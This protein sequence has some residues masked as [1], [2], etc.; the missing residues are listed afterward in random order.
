MR[1]AAHGR[2]VTVPELPEVETLRQDLNREVVGRKVKAVAVGNG[3]SVRRHQSAK[4]FRALLEGRTIKSVSRLGKYL[5]LGLDNGDSLVVHLGMSG[6]LLRVKS[7]KDPKPKHTHVVLTFTQ[8]GELRYVDPRTFGEMFVS[9]APVADGP[10]PASTPG[11]SLGDGRMI[12][13]SVPELA[14]LGFDPIEDVLTWERF[15]L[16]LRSRRAGLKALL[17]DQQFVAGI[18]NLYS[19]EILFTAGLRYDRSSD[20]LSPT[21]VRRLYRSLLETLADAIKHRGSTLADEGYRDLFGESGA[22]QGQHQVY[23]REGQPCPRCRNPIV[24]VK[25]GGRSTFY[26]EHCQV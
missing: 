7:A 14:H 2:S 23:D 15:A 16:M 10:A 3:R 17:M 12:R 11:P 6:Q 20:S 9:T 24:R 5:V 18:G 19:D 25:W 21:E 13:Q 22:F 8:G 4:H 26:C 1:R